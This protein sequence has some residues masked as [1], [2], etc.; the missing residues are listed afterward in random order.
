MTSTNVEPDERPTAAGIYDYF[1]GGDQATP[2]EAAAASK[3]ISIQPTIPQQVR[4]NRDF[5]GRAVRALAAA[6]V[7]Q[8]LDI[9][10]GLPSIDNVHA[11][12]RQAEPTSRTIYVDFDP[13]VVNR[14]RALLNREGVSSS[15]RAV[16]G[17]VRDIPGLLADS[18]MDL[19]DFDQPV[20]VLMVALLHFVAGP[21]EEVGELTAGKLAE[22][23]APGSYLVVTH[24]MVDSGPR[25][26]LTETV[27]RAESNTNGVSINRTVAEVEQL[28]HG[29]SL[30]EP[31]IVPAQRWRG[32]DMPAAPLEEWDDGDPGPLWAASGVAKRDPLWAAAGVARHA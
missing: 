22:A 26:S 28:F 5:L 11:I 18:Q 25:E 24:G 23:L 1:L 31:G 19:F 4:L 12:A 7:R 6:G 27:E 29:W 14:S 30:L 20:A 16:V 9:G 10:S 32:L 2:A 21:A 15:V 17:D 3:L 8:F 13:Q